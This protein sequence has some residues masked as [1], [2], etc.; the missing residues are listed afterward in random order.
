MFDELLDTYCVVLSL[1]EL[2]PVVTFPEIIPLFTYP[3]YMFTVLLEVV[4]CEVPT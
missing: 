4:G 3:F 1:M 2:F